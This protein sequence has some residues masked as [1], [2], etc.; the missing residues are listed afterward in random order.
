[1]TDATTV[2]RTVSLYNRDYTI[3][4]SKEDEPRLQQL[5]EVVQK[6]METVA[7]NIGNATEARHLMLTCLS[8]ADKL[9][10]ARAASYEQIS[11]Q[12]DIFVS[13]VQHLRQRVVDLSSQ[14]GNA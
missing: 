2:K 12:E 11:K 1:M 8:L 5:V 14:I 9:L 13:A 3:N 10:E 6:E 7:G 4:C